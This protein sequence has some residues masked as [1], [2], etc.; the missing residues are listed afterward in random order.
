MARRYLA[1]LRSHGPGPYLLGGYSGG[2][3]VALE[4]AR[5]LQADGEHVGGVV[6]FDSPIGKISLGRRVHAGHL[7]RNLVTRG[8]GPVLPIVTS[9]LHGTTLGRRLLFR[10]RRSI[11][12]ISHE[13]N[14]ED[15][16][17]HGFN[18]LYDHFTDVS[19]RFA[20]GHYD[21]DAILVKAQLRWP[22]MS[23]DYG[24]S[25]HITGRLDVVIAKGDHESMFSAQNAPGLAADLAPLIDRFDEAT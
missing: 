8:P 1:A 11:D 4:M 12:E 9:R 10:G 14:Y 7:L 18:D 22:L 20:V 24:W 5:L 13:A 19:E 2:G 17:A 6:L 25:D 23:D 21:V 15:M 16:Q 3:A